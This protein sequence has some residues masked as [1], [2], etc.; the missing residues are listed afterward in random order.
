MNLVSL[1]APLEIEQM[2]AGAI[3]M[4]MK[5]DQTYSLKNVLPISVI[6]TKSWQL[7]FI[8]IHMLSFLG[9]SSFRIH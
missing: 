5:V 3:A 8:I 2:E 7:P 1:K 6:L 9:E 4:A